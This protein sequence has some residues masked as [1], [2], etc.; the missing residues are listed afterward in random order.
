MLPVAAVLVF[1]L[2]MGA[3]LASLFRRRL[4]RW[5]PLSRTA[6]AAVAVT[7]LGTA[8]VFSCA[9]SASPPFC[10]SCPDYSGWI[11][12]GLN[13]LLCGPMLVYHLRRLSLTLDTNTAYSSAALYAPVVLL[14][15]F[16]GE[17]LI[18]LP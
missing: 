7:S 2:A 14:A 9:A 6:S 1:S 3:F 18:W 11:I 17:L 4:G 10:H 5:P 8:L 16:D 12:L 13:F 15:V